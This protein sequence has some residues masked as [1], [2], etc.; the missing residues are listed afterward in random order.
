[1]Q[2][3]RLLVIFFLF[4]RDRN[5]NSSYQT[6]ANEARLLLAEGRGHELGGEHEVAAEWSDGHRDFR[7][8]YMANLRCVAIRAKTVCIILALTATRNLRIQAGLSR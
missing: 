8:P 3:F 6:L 2:S 1:M 5:Y 7:M 4:F